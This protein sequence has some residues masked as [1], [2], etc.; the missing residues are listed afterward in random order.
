M[1]ANMTEVLSCN[2]FD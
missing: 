2:C 1:S